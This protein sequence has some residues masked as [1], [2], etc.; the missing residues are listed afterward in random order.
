VAAILTRTTHEVVAKPV[1]AA[2]LAQRKATRNFPLAID[3][4]RPLA[5]GTLGALAS[6]SSADNPGAAEDVVKHP[7]KL[8][9][10]AARTLGRTLRTG[11]VG[12]VRVQG[13]RVA[14]ASLAQSVA[15]FGV[16][17]GSSL[18]SRK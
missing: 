9:E 12:E 2:E 7:P 13:G 4:A 11:V 5:H 15:G 16:D 3:V 17:F 10:V 6:L 1:A 18:R 8:G 14:D